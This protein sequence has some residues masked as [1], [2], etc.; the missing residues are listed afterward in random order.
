MG[1]FSVQDETL[2]PLL[3]TPFIEQH[4]V[5]SPDEKLIAFQS[6][7]TGRFEV[8]VQTFPDP[9]NRWRVSTNGGSGPVWRRDGRE[10]FSSPTKPW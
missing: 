7:E 3:T 5:I 2:T 1:V 4:G 8:Y 9:V 10:L 6:N